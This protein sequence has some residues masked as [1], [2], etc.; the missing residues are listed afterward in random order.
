MIQESVSRSIS[1]KSS[2]LPIVSCIH[3]VWISRLCRLTVAVRLL[4]EHKGDAIYQLEAF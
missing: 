1:L 4:I 3:V 2:C